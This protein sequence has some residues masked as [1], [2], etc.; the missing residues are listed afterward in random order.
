MLT[1]LGV[2]ALLGTVVGAPAAA[3]Q[4]C[5][6]TVVAP[7]PAAYYRYES[8][9]ERLM[10]ERRERA[11]RHARWLHQHRFGFGDRGGFHGRW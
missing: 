2:S 11:F 1:N 4:P 5:N 6:T 8:A 10:R 7:Q 3:Q 9:W